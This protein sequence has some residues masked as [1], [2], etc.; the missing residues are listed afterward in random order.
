MKR[1]KYLMLGLL[2]ILTL[3]TQV[4]ASEIPD[5]LVVQ[6]INGQQQLVK[7]YVLSPDADPSVLQEPSFD[8]DGFHYTW[9]YTTKKEQPYLDTKFVVKTTTVETATNDLSEI[10]E[11]LPHN[12]PYKQDGYS[13]ELTL[14]HT[15]LV[16]E[17]AGY[18]TKYRT[19]TYTKVIGNLDRNDMSYVPATTIKDGKTLSLVDVEWQITGT[20]LVGEALMPSRYQAVA[21]YSASSSYSVATGYVTTAAY[22][23]EV[24]A[25]GIESVTYT[26]VFTGTEIVPDDSNNGQSHIFLPGRLWIVVIGAVL[27]TLLLAA[28]VYYLLRHRKNVYV[29][30][31]GEHPRDYML[32]AKFRVTPA[33]PEID[34]TAVDT[35]P[36]HIV[37]VE[38]KRTL[39]KKMMGQIVTVHHKFGTHRYSIVQDQRDDWHE[40]QLKEVSSCDSEKPVA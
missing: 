25:E 39:A 7:T 8:Y 5:N 35:S 40:F 34:I 15:T 4:F 33:Q 3:T 11:Q 10:L 2:L 1:L 37:A 38:I 14:D 36:D 6:N 19:I 23:G 32:V 18:T 20:D 31:P 30:V 21:T 29:Y 26:V 24:T 27:L 9:A 16:T 28:F 12:T 22:C 13:G 17:A